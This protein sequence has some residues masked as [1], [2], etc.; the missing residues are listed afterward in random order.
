MEEGTAERVGLDLSLTAICRSRRARC[1]CVEPQLGKAPSSTQQRG[2]GSRNARLLLAS[3]PFLL[4][5]FFLLS[6]ISLLFQ[7]RGIYCRFCFEAPIFTSNLERV[8]VTG[9]LLEQISCQPQSV[10]QI[11]RQSSPWFCIV[12]TLRSSNLYANSRCFMFNRFFS[13]EYHRSDAAF[14]AFFTLIQTPIKA[15]SCVCV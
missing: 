14:S 4:R 8:G 10:H 9:E 3:P 1:F 13:C 11:F 6:H 7:V 2:S 15:R 12:L 5:R